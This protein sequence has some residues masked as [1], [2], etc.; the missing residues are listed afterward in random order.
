MLILSFGQTRYLRVRRKQTATQKQGEFINVELEDNSLV[1]ME[2]NDFQRVW[3]HQ[4]DKLG[5][6]D[7]IRERLSLNLRF[8]GESE[9]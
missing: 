8:K 5:K 9:K 1:V 4:V 2:G 7:S 3:Q 6:N